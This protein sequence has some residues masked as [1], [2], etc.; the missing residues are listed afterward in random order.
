MRILV[1]MSGGVDSAVAAAR[2][3]HAGHDVTGVHL[4]LSKN[5]AS[6][7]SGARGCCSLEDS[8]D[9]RRV[10]DKLDIDFYVWDFAEEFHE[11]VVEDFIAEYQ[12]GRTPNPC[13]RCNEKIKFAAVLDRGIALGFDAVATGHYADLRRNDDGTVSLWRAADEAKDQSYVLGMLNQQQLSRCLF[14]LHDVEKPMVREEARALGFGVAKKPDS[15]DICFIA[16]GDTQGFLGRYLDDAPG[17]IV[18]AEG[19]V[20]GE[21]RGTHRY[22]V[23]QRKGLDLRVPT[24]TGEPRYVLRIEPLNN[25]VVVGSRADLAVSTLRAIRPTWTESPVAGPWRGT[26]QYRA[27]GIPQSATIEVA[28]G[29]MT[30]ALDEPASG[31]APGQ[32]VVVYDDN[33]VVGCAVI[34]EAR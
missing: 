21:H 25:T 26:A 17:P 18:D 10:A 7:R 34:A 14:P 4:A 3:V 30:V 23:G 5:P 29:E 16:D 15:H 2:L 28:D 20:L 22:T 1:A 32:T 27:H 11:A 33:R 19:A 9:A 13:L 8:H 12:A 31:V 6:Y 24:P